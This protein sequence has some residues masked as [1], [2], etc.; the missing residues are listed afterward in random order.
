MDKSEKAPSIPDPPPVCPGFP[1]APQAAGVEQTGLTSK[2]EEV[3][4][5][6]A[7]RQVSFKADTGRIEIEFQPGGV[8]EH[9][10]S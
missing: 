8:A 7:I 6:N 5:R 1:L 3:A 10:A 4:L 9:L 2:E